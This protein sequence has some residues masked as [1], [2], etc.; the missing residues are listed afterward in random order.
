MTTE[1]AN[2]LLDYA[3]GLFRFMTEY[4]GKV[5][6]AKL[7]HFPNPDFV[8]ETLDHF[9]VN[10]SA[11]EDWQEGNL[12]LLA[13]SERLNSELRRLGLTTADEA[14]RRERESIAA[15]RAD[16]SSINRIIEDL[17][18]EDL[19]ELKPQAL[20][21]LENQKAREMFKDKGV[22]DSKTLR[23]LVYRVVREGAAA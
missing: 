1:Q 13:I 4:Q 9:A 14:K 3:K 12:P 15:V 23:W 11:D 5:L 22:R 21:L 16:W 8:E 18:D 7:E 6:K 20:M 19:A 10:P 17:S 2:R